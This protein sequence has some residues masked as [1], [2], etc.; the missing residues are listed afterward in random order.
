LGVLERDSFDVLEGDVG[1][2]SSGEGG[3]DKI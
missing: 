1:G 3:F 2:F